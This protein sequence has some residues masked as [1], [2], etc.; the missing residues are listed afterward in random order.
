[1]L[2]GL[3][4]PK[5]CLQCRRNSLLT[6]ASFAT[7]SR[8]IGSTS[9]TTTGIPTRGVIPPTVGTPFMP[10]LPRVWLR[11]SC[12][13]F[14][15]RSSFCWSSLGSSLCLR[16]D[17]IQRWSPS[18]GSHRFSYW[19]SS[20]KIV[21]RKGGSPTTCV[22]LPGPLPEEPSRLKQSSNQSNSPCLPDYVST[23]EPQ[24]VGA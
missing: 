24:D 14:R 3:G 10:S 1:M 22:L 17:R 2:E 12:R 9:T 8:F 11:S 5:A 19:Q 13:V 6:L 20:R 15:T 4:D 23:M 16:Q 18:I 7:L 21:S